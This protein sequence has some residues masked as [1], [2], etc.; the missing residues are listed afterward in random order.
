M[1]IES[2]AYER[3]KLTLETPDIRAAMRFAYTFK[4]GDY[5]IAKSRKR[6]SLDANAYAWALMDKL[7]QATGLPKAEVY[8]NTIRDIG[9]VS[10][11]VC[12]PSEGAPQLCRGWEHNGLGWQAE[13]TSSK[14][15]GCTNVILYYGSSAYDTKQMSRLIDR[16][17]EDCRALEIETKPEEEIK[18][19]LEAWK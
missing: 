3:G 10:E 15:S 13:T 1:R 9:G 17:V 16:L 7:S 11:T 12:V 8:R 2:V 18:S 14:I 19:L 5:E 4:A 6:R